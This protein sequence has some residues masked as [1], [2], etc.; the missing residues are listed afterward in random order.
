[1]TDSTPDAAAP[2][3]ET[4]PR[5]RRW[6]LWSLLTL[7]ALLAVGAVVAHQVVAPMMIRKV[8]RQELQSRWQGP[9]EIGEVTFSLTE[10]IVIHDVVLTDDDGR[11][12]ATFGQMEVVLLDW[13]ATT[14]RITE[15]NFRQAELAAHLG[16]RP[17]LK[18]PTPEPD[19]TLKTLPTLVTILVEAPALTIFSE[20]GA[21]RRLTDLRIEA[22]RLPSPESGSPVGAMW[23]LAVTINDETFPT[24]LDGTVVLG[25]DQVV[26]EA[27]ACV[28]GP[29]IKVRANLAGALDR[30]DDSAPILLAAT[31]TGLTFGGLSEAALRGRLSPAGGLELWGQATAKMIDLH[32]L[33]AAGGWAQPDHGTLS[34]GEWVG[35][36]DGVAL[37]NLQGHGLVRADDVAVSEFTLFRQLA[38]AINPTRQMG[39][40]DSD[41]YAIF[42]LADGITTIHIG[43]MVD[44]LTATDVHDGSTVDLI[45]GELDLAV[46]AAVMDDIT[47][48]LKLLPIIGPAAGLA[49]SVIH[50]DVTGTWDEPVITPAPQ[51]MLT[52][53]LIGFLQSA[54]NFGGDLGAFFVNPGEDA[55]TALLQDAAIELEAT[56]P[57]PPAEPAQPPS[58]LAAPRWGRRAQPSQD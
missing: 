6:L 19:P 17:P 38:R 40:G 34:Q 49:N 37:T 32:R 56:W 28:D 33:A 57:K 46:S 21:A 9:I 18:G 44:V 11:T 29:D 1:M 24:S 2:S 53:N 55:M 52:D 51:R 36:T 42:A 16:H 48:L 45:T 20:D 13:P 43:R 3:P 35:Y 7:V 54:T 25:A 23:Q 12:W 8:V 39:T 50:L 41:G 15:L 58:P 27:R 30:T 31:A 10:P 26:L 4:K 47:P 14:I 22:T 5:R